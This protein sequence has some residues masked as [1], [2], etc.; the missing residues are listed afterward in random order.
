MRKF[1][2]AFLLQGLY[3]RVF[4]F[5]EKMNLHDQSGRF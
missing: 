1:L 3:L 2:L 4:M 5:L